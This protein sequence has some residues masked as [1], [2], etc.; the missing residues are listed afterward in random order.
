MSGGP[1]FDERDSFLYT[2]GLY[3]GAVSPHLQGSHSSLLGC[4]WILNIPWTTKQQDLVFTEDRP[5]VIP[6]RL[7]CHAAWVHARGLPIRRS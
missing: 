3:T 2:I 6:P 7:Y 1:A 4:C 5:A